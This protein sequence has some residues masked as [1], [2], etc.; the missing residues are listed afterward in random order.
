M[1]EQAQKRK[2]R[3]RKCNVVKSRSFIGKEKGRKKGGERNRKNR[4]KKQ[5][6]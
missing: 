5:E 6:M 3:E 2:K 1:Q 4:K